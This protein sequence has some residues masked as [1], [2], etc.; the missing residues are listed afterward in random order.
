MPRLPEKGEAEWI[1]TLGKGFADD[2]YRVRDL[3]RTIATDP[4]FYKASG[5]SAPAEVKSAKSQAAN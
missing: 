1:K 5:P 2:G 3:V 4:A